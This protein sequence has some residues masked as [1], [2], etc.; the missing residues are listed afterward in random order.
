MGQFGPKIQTFYL[1]FMFKLFHSVMFSFC[2]S[3][4]FKILEN[5]SALR[6]FLLMNNTE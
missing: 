1:K 6:R 5:A 4:L 3:E 2:F